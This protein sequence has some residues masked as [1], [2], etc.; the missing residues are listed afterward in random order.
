MSSGGTFELYGPIGIFIL[1]LPSILPAAGSLR[2][3]YRALCVAAAAF[4]ALSG[5]AWKIYD[6]ASWHSYRVPPLF[7]ARRVVVHPIYGPMVIDN[8]QREFFDGMCATIEHGEATPSVLSL[9]FPYV[10]Y[11]CGVTPWKN[12]VQTFFDTS[13]A[14]VIHTLIAD[15]GSAPPEWIL[16]QRQLPSLAIH[17][18]LYN[19][20]RRLPHRDL[21]DLIMKKLASGQWRIVHREAYG[22][23]SDWILIDTRQAVGPIA[24]RTAPVK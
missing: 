13:S 23:N 7:A 8:R 17:E 14:E 5:V 1:I 9:P 18:R 24:R 3:P 4:I 22:A 11:Y 21:D 10:N 2:E 19:S 12:Y 16:Y 20:G 15:L 6:P